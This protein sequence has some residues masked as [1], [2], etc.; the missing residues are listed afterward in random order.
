M[1]ALTSKITSA[2]TTLSKSYFSSAIP[3]KVIS[4]LNDLIR[5][6]GSC[7]RGGVLKLILLPSSYLLLVDLWAPGIGYY[8]GA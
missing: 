7:P 4:L 6:Y 5:N 8:Y 2:S 3:Y 1:T